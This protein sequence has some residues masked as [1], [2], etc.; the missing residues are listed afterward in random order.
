LKRICFP[1]RVLSDHTEHMENISDTIVQDIVAEE[2]Q[3]GQE[4]T[5]DQFTNNVEAKAEERVEEMKELFGS[6]ID[7]VAGQVIDNAKSYG[8]SRREV[9]DGS[10]FVGD[11]HAIGAAAYTNMADRTVTYD[12]SAMDYGSQH[13]AYW[14]RVEKHEA[15]HQKDQAGVYNATTVAYV[16][17]SG[18]FVE[19]KVDALVEWQ[20]SSKANIPSDLTPE[21]NQH[22]EDG[23][24]VAEVAGK[25]AVEEALKTGDM[26]GLQQEIIRK[27]LPAILKAAGVKA[28]EDEYAMA[29]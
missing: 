2:Q 22:V 1:T 15:I 5:V 25:D 11:A 8:E 16:D 12:T 9:L 4:V 17:Q 21:Y 14:G 20:P 7:V 13:D 6:Q 29:G 10:A 3:N 28:P 24:A 23:D 18:V 26:V 27:Q 19:T